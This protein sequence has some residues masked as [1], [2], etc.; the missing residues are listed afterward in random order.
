MDTAK[1]FMSGR[2]QAVRLPKTYRFEGTGVDI[3]RIGNGVALLPVQDSWMLLFDALDQFSGDYM[4]DREQP[5][6]QQ[7]REDLFQQYR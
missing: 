1:P 7:K 5:Q 6:Q 3:K 4:A 2:S